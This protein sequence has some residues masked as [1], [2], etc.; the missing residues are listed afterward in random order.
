VPRRVTIKKASAREFNHNPGGDFPVRRG[1]QLGVVRNGDREEPKVLGVNG[2]GT[3]GSSKNQGNEN[4]TVHTRQS[5]RLL[6]AY[7]TA[8]PPRGA[9]GEREHRQRPTAL[10]PTCRWDA[11]FLCNAAIKATQEHGPSSAVL[12]TLRT[13]NAVFETLDPNDQLP[14]RLDGRRGR[15]SRNLNHTDGFFNSPIGLGGTAARSTFPDGGGSGEA[16]TA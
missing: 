6:R 7:E 15:R 3:E 11:R 16:K 10:P 1:G 9:V 4:R 5:A 14:A 12:P 13:G 8:I 2:D